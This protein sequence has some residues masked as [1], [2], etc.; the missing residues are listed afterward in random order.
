MINLMEES[1]STHH[2]SL[3]MYTAAGEQYSKISFLHYVSE[4]IVQL[5]LLITFS[6]FLLLKK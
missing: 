3:A 6:S 4:M 5:M 1:T 2:Q